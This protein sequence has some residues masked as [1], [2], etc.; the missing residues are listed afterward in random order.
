M[1]AW[2]RLGD[3]EKAIADLGKAIRLDPENPNLLN[4]R[5][6]LRATCE[7]ESF[8]DG[9]QAVADATEACE[10]TEWN[11]PKIVDTLAAAYAESGNFEEAVKWQRKAVELAPAEMKTELSS[12]IELYQA[13]KAYRENPNE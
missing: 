13:G 1:I 4:E 10:L 9:R 8:R 11:D 2:I 6:W 3:F 5:A 7:E 12:R